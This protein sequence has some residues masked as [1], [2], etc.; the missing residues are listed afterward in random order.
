MIHPFDVYSLV[1]SGSGVWSPSRVQL[2]VTPMDCSP[3]GLSVPHHLLT[4]AQVHVH[5]IG[6][7]IQPSHP[8]MPSSSALNHSQHQLW[9]YCVINYKNCG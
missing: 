8:L 4:F 2:F 1:L 3:P 7:A 5:Y 6:G 9:V